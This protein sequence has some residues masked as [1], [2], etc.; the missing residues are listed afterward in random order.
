MHTFEAKVGFEKYPIFIGNSIFKELN[1][2]IKTYNKKNV[3]II[4]DSFFKRSNASYISDLSF[5]YNYYCLFIDGGIE[6]KTIPNYENIMK[7]IVRKNIARDGLIVAIGGGVIGDLSAFIASTYQRGIDLVHV[8]TTTTAMIDSSLGGKTGLNFLDQVNLIGSYYNPKAIFMDLN[9]LSTL[10]ERDFFSGICESIK[11]AITS[12]KDMFN[13]FFSIK[14]L[15]NSRDMK[16]L[17]DI[18]F[19]SVLTKLKH[20]SGDFKE[21]S[22]RL[23]LNYGHTFGQSIETYY[24]LY[25]DKLK[26]GEAVA[27]GITVAAKLS[28]LLINNFESQELFVKTNELLSIYNL[29]NKFNKINSDDIPSISELTKNIINDKKRISEGNR[30]ILCESIGKANV[31]IIK[32]DDLIANSFKCLY[33]EIK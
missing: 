24:G 20:V 14:S 13:K 2:F 22:K 9:F 27:L 17:E 5:I 33:D 26:H 4:S 7:V 32:R 1:S 30:F 8:P 10:S 31:K 21:K 6:S 15:V 28:N 12:D 16:T 25:Q 19:W 18:I 29:P 11:M 23:I 3:F